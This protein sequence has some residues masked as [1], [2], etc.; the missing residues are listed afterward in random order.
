MTIDHYNLR[1]FDLNLLLAFDALMQTRSVTGA[2]HILKLQQPAMSH[3]LS[4]LR[5]LLDDPLLKRVGSRMEPTLRAEAIAVKVREILEQT[6]SVLA[7]GDAFAP[8]RERRIVRIAVNGQI[9]AFLLPALAARLVRLSPHIRLLVRAASRHEVFDLLDEVGVDL[10]VGYFP[11]GG[12]QHLRK[13]IYRESL[14]CCWHP[15]QLPLHGP[16]SV[17]AYLG[18]RH[19]LV[20]A[21]NNMVGYLED[22]LNAARLQPDVAMSSPHFV[23]LMSTAR[24]MP[25]MLTLT[26]RVAASYA[27]LFE[28]SVSDFPVRALEIPVDLLWHMRADRDPATIW[29]RE[30]IEG[31]A[32]ELEER[33]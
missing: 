21:K 32:A 15:S 8:E 31:V 33:P 29:L 12:S 24:L 17:P 26:T 4:T 2:A 22:F 16:I 7:R 11:G 19:G 10:A 9:E 27:P 18:V 5:L 28:L 20:S 1:S 23:T 14:S 13:T 25:L 3:A 6:Q 30:Q